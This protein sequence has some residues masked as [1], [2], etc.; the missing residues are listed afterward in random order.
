[1]DYQ[2]A[3][4]EVP[5]VFAD[6]TVYETEVLDEEALR[7]RVRCSSGT[8]IRALCRDLARATG[9]CGHM[10][11]LR[12][13]RAGAFSL[14]EAQPLDADCH[15]VYP[16][17]TALRDLPRA[18]GLDLADVRNGKHLRIGTVHD[19]VLIDDEAGQPLA[20]YDRMQDDVFACARGLW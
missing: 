3:G 6:V 13:T 20:V 5:P 9:N 2:R 15:T 1:M 19:R 18:D 8:Y 7:F 14:T 4:K 12:R 17:K 11:S 16:L 10:K